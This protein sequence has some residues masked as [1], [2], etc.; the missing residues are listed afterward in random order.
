MSRHL[1]VV[2][3]LSKLVCCLFL[4]AILASEVE[5]FDKVVVEGGFFSVDY[6]I[7]TVDSYCLVIVQDRESEDLSIK[8][9][10]ALHKSEEFDNTSHC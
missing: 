9:F 2:D 3:I 7:M 8:L 5:R 1:Y 10:F 6:K 4:F